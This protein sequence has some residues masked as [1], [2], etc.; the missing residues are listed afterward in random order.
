MQ[1][2]RELFTLDVTDPGK[3]TAMTMT[4]LAAKKAFDFVQ[5]VE[6]SGALIR[7]RD[8]SG[9][10][11]LSLRKYKHPVLTDRPT[12]SRTDASETLGKTGP[13]ARLQ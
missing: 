13:V 8:G 3:I 6:D 12:L 10:V 11:L 5:D 9:V 7:Y 1:D 4:H 2:G